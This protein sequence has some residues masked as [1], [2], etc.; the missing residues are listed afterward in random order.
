MTMDH[1]GVYGGLFRCGQ[2]L[3]RSKYDLVFFNSVS[4]YTIEQR[5]GVGVLQKRST[6]QNYH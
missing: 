5:A 4:S 1:K 2:A 3:P 6:S